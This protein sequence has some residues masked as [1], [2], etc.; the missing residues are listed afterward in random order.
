MD[1][2]SRVI[3]SPQERS[4]ARFQ[5]CKRAM[6]RICGE[7][8]THQG[9]PSRLHVQVRFIRLIRERFR[10]N[11]HG[12]SAPLLSAG[13]FVVDRVSS[14]DTFDCGLEAVGRCA[15]TETSGGGGVAGTHLRAL[16]LFTFIRLQ[17]S[18]LWLG[19]DVGSDDRVEWGHGAQSL[20]QKGASVRST[21]L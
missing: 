5:D 18:D 11:P 21:V 1:G 7:T 19:S 10:G 6:L 8:G 12:P 16:D 14:F 3:V 2:Y 4:S 20:R 15:T 13:L 9:N 17:P